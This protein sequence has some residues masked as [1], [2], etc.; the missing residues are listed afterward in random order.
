MQ[1]ALLTLLKFG[2]VILLYLFLARVV[3]A[4]LIDLYGPRKK[5][6]KAAEP[7]PA[8]PSTSSR[9]RTS[10]TMPKEI[11][12]HPPTGRPE[13]HALGSKGL[14]LGR[15]GQASVILD[16]VYVS[17][18]HA[19]VLADEGGWAVRDLGSTNGTFLNGA[20][21]TRPTQLAAGDQLRVGKT[22]VEVRR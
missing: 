4:L 15:S 12:V 9:S 6:R 14:I 22:N 21:V 8:A 20:K 1:M 10:R 13:T 17:D 11:V 5:G 19:E 7:R 18:E 2:V 3:R 16:D